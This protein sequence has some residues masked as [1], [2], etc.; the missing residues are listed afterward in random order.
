M[1]TQKL[2]I[3][4]MFMITFA[5]VMASCAELSVDNNN[6][7]TTE[8]VLEDPANIL[9][10]LGGGFSDFS[11]A[12]ITSY[13]VHP[14]LM[15]DQNTSTNNVR[16]FWAF[17]DEPRLPM[18]NTTA[19]GSQGVYTV[20][21]GGFNA[22]VA[23]SNI[24]IKQIEVDG[25]IIM[26]EGVD[27]TGTVLAQAYFLRGL[28]RGYL[29]LMYD[30]G[31]LLDENFDPST[32]PDFASY[33]DLIA[34][35]LSD[36]DNTISL[37]EAAASFE[38]NVMPNGDDVWTKNEFLTIANSMAAR[39]A[40][41]E[42]RTRAEADNLDWTSILAYANKGIGG[43]NAA[44]AD[45]T[46]WSPSNVGS[47][48][49]F[50]NYMSDWLNFVVT[51][52]PTGAPEDL[53]SGYLPVD[54]KQ[55]HL[56]DP[57]YPTAYPAAEA[58]AST[59]SLAPSTTTD[60]RIAYF[61]YTTNPGFLNPTRNA[62]LFSNYFS[63]RLHGANDW[64]PST[65]KVTLMTKTE[66]DMLRAE[67][68]V[69]LGQSALAAP[70]LNASSAGTNPTELSWDLPGVQLGYVAQNSLAGGYTLDGTENEAQMQWALLRE[71]S[72][73]LDNLGGAG[74]QWF[75][76]RRHDMLQAG[77]PL[78]YPVPGSELEILGL[79]N[80]TFGGADF[81]GQVGTSDGANSWQ[82]LYGKTGLKV[83]PS[84]SK[85]VVN[86]AI[87]DYQLPVEARPSAPLRSEM[88]DN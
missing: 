47:A 28:A 44:D 85:A 2:K 13:A 59:A 87:Q 54:V 30:Q 48:G 55:I 61:Q 6:E 79:D 37:V 43:P 82:D 7:P 15:A 88:K 38:F 24:F 64:W 32:T 40:A 1:K 46:D 39:I 9:K 18:N 75:F 8:S 81:A 71:Y 26:D 72:V 56:M 66:V 50:A 22:A 5:V 45:L 65:N 27:V 70:I 67:A 53:G 60:P 57:T 51:G 31:Y 73:E 76:M 74:I 21:F 63:L 80:Y 29:G 77:T 11:S 25:T 20:F 52:S 78:N 84:A 17:A 3:I 36:L 35:S 58:S 86:T 41:G 14:N 83:N 49:E 16:A 12:V 4:S 69:M 19:F 23:T 33:S 62:A 42:A 10:L 34:G 68:N